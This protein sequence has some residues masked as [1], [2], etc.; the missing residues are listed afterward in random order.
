MHIS[1]AAMDQASVVGTRTYW[2]QK[3]VLCVAQ[4]PLI[5]MKSRDAKSASP[6]EEKDQVDKDK[7]KDKEGVG[8]EEEKEEEQ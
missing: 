2:N 1:E 7:D 8:K 4:R 3:P 5:F 6:K